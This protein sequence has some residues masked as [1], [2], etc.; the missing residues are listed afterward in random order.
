MVRDPGDY[1]WSSYRCNAGTTHD[2]HVTPHDSWL[3]WAKT[4]QHARQ[5]IARSSMNACSK[6]TWN[7]CAAAWTRV[8]P[9]AMTAS[10]V[11]S[12]ASSQFNSEP[13]RAG[14]Q[15]KMTTSSRPV[16]CIRPQSIQ[17]FIKCIRP[18]LFRA[19]LRPQGVLAV[20][21]AGP[22]AD[23][24]QRLRKAGFSVDEVRVPAHGRKGARHV[25]WVAQ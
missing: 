9:Q 8:Y 14:D 25:I 6:T 18:H 13:A 15:G 19:A 23:F 16:K 1:P 4:M 21:S 3:P 11:K 5:R 10:D 24:T 22:D 20:W 12:S 7:G 17:A 2:F